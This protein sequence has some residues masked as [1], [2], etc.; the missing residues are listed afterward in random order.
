MIN[1]SLKTREPGALMSE[2]R[3]NRTPQLKKRENIPFLHLF[4]SLGA[5][6]GLDDASHVGEDR[7]LLIPLIQM[8]ISS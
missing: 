4:V 5:L 8:L 1:L 7:S 2:G 6:S 3:R